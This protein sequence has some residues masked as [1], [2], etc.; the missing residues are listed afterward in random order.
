MLCIYINSY[1]HA[2]MIFSVTWRACGP[3]FFTGCHPPISCWS[4][5][6][7]MHHFTEADSEG[8]HTLC[9]CCPPEGSD[10]EQVLGRSNAG[11][12]W[13]WYVVFLHACIWHCAYVHIACLWRAKVNDRWIIDTILCVDRNSS[14]SCHWKVMGAIANC[15]MGIVKL[16]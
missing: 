15:V 3:I 5:S 10:Y 2:C 16:V 13:L 11:W 7:K 4:W 1:C 9:Y 8:K 12:M 14:L 6:L